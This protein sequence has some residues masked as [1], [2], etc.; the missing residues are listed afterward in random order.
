MFY[1]VLT[2]CA[3]YVAAW[4]G[5]VGFKKAHDELVTNVASIENASKVQETNMKGAA[6]DKR[7]KREAMTAKAIE[8]ARGVF[9]YAEDNGDLV[10]R[11]QM[12]LSANDLNRKRDSV[13]SALAQGVHDVANG[14]VAGLSDYGLV[15]ADLSDLQGKI[16]AYVAVVSAPRNAT[17]VRKGATAEIN[18][19]VK[20]SMKILNNR[21][22]KLMPEFEQSHPEFF[23]EYFDAR[24]IVD[25]GGSQSNDADAPVADAA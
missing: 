12:N 8:V 22:D 7:F 18:A 16:D 15:P 19:L 11:E 2:V 24:I 5:V 6:L 1:A 13:V 20:D 25:N 10:L 3:K 17:G 14:I 9:A 23:Q 21:M 4:T